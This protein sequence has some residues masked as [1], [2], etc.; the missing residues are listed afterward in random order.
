MRAHIKPIMRGWRFFLLLF[1]SSPA[2]GQLKVA[3]FN[4]SLYRSQ[5]AELLPDLSQGNGS[6]IKSIAEII[7]RTN[8]DVLL[9][10]EFDY[11]PNNAAVDLFQ[12]IL[13]TPQNNL[14]V[15]T[16]GQ[17]IL[18]PYRRAFESNTGIASGFD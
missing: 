17:P 16:S 12:T 1:L 18:Y 3:T 6:Q 9:I 2:M 15:P 8:P 10:N 14:N 11:S 7:Q 5:P 13:S 4:A